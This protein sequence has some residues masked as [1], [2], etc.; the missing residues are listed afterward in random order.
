MTPSDATEILFRY[1]SRAHT[2]HLPS[3]RWVRSE[4]EAKELAEACMVVLAL[5][6]GQTEAIEG[7]IEQDARQETAPREAQR[8]Q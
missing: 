8:P 1:A 6:K 5:V 2:K 7:L 4:I 3:D